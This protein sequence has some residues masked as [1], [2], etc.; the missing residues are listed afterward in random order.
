M[1]HRVLREQ[2]HRGA[3]SGRLVSISLG[4]AATLT[5]LLITVIAGEERGAT[6]AE[7]TVWIATGVVILLAAHLLPALIKGAGMSV[8]GIVLP[9]WIGALLATGYTHATFFLNAQGRVGEQRASA[10][11]AMRSVPAL[12]AVA[13]TRSRTQIAADVAATH[14]NLA[15]LDT[16]R[17][18][19]DCAAVAARRK[20]LSARIEA[21]RIEDVEAVRAE[22]SSDARTAAVER[23]QRDQDEARVDPFV[24][25]LATFLRLGAN[26]INLIIAIVLGW[27]VDAVAVV[28]WASVARPQARTATPETATQTSVEASDHQPSVVCAAPV[29]LI[30]AAANEPLLREKVAAPDVAERESRFEPPVAAFSEVEEGDQ[31]I[32]LA[33]LAAAIRA[34]RVKST[35]ASIRA[36]LGCTDGAAMAFRRRLAEDHP[37]LFRP[38]PRVG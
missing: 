8:K 22:K 2:S 20:V 25:D 9:I 11:A 34:G 36:H 14:R 5:S 10:V 37:E 23:S 15:L 28:S 17:C 4:I 29:F 16:R 21:L 19:T 26:Q 1:A 38:V 6:W 24:A 35:L 12:P 30:R 3:G 13:N 33:D 18:S 31:V 7:K 27:L 32:D